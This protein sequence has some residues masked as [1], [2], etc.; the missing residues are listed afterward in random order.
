MPPGFQFPIGAESP[1][2]ENHRA[3]GA[4]YRPQNS[5]N[6]AARNP[7]FTGDHTNEARHFPGGSTV[8]V[9]QPVA[10]NLERQYPGRQTSDPGAGVVP[11]FE[12]LVGDVK[13][14][15]L[16]LLGAVGFILL[17]ACANVASLLLA[18]AAGRQR[19]IAIRAALGAG[20]HRIVRQLI[21]EN[22]LL[23]FLSSAL[24]L[25]IAVGGIRAL[26]RL[27]AH[28]VPRLEQISLDG[29][30]LGL[31]LAVVTGLLFGFVQALTASKVHLT[32][33]LEAG[34]RGAAATNLLALDPETFWW[35]ERRRY[36][37]SCLLVRAC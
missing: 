2:S 9:Y 8:D 24:G 28:H 13:P 23:A 33:S 27:M 18:R 17:I 11:E 19:E 7:L 3:R 1:K 26:V 30:V 20:R 21:T 36:H 34:G 32:E 5:G 22:T 29:R 35:W 6:S 15:L 25:T 14:A 12:A 37:W 10:R 16:L 31:F 4:G